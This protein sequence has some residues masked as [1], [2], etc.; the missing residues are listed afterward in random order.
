MFLYN[1]DGPVTIEINADYGDED[2]WVI[3]SNLQI[4]DSVDLAENFDVKPSDEKEGKPGM[5]V[6]ILTRNKSWVN[7]L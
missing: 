3:T 1:H 7:N 4:K 6:S 5:L 2:G